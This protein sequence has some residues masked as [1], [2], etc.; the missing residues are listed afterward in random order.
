MVI[1]QLKLR[2][3]D[4]R[5]ERA[6]PA[7]RS[8]TRCAGRAAARA[9]APRLRWGWPSRLAAHRTQRRPRRIAAPASR[10]FKITTPLR[11]FLAM[12]ARRHFDYRGLITQASFCFVIR[13]PP[14]TRTP[15]PSNLVMY[16]QRTRLC[17]GARARRLTTRRCTCAQ[18]VLPLEPWM[19]RA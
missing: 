3:L 8:R 11:F 19:M 16:R 9:A 1:L 2:H 14:C 7:G 15:S 12:R 13:S 17:A 18:P 5:S 6:R 4:V 10:G